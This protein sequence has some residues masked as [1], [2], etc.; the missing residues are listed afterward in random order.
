MKN[1]EY[2][3]PTKNKYVVSIDGPAGAGKSTISY[4]LAQKLNFIHLDSG[5]LYRSLA[6]LAY[7]KSLLVNNVPNY[8]LEHPNIFCFSYQNCKQ[9]IYLGNEFLGE[10]IRTLAIT[11]Q[12]KNFANNP[13]CRKWVNSLMQS[14]SKNLSL[15]VDGRDIG[16][17]VFPNAKYKFFLI[18]DIETRVK[19]RALEKNITLYSLEYQKLKKTIIARDKHDTMRKIAALKQAT[20]AILIDTSNLS[21]EQI[22]QAILSLIVF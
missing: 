8:I 14:I 13:A 17:V 9:Q 15:V 7:K 12:I 3:L 11:K 6:Y 19:R 22:I 5:A 18:A 20:D 21:K 2:F 1:Q 16:T 10:Q 4:L